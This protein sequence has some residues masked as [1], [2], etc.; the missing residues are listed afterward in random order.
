MNNWNKGWWK[1]RF[2]EKMELVNYIQECLYKDYSIPKIADELG[3]SSTTIHIII[4]KNN[5]VERRINLRSKDWLMQKYIE[6]K[7]SMNEIAKILGVTYQAV[8]FYIKKFNIQKRDISE[9]QKIASQRYRRNSNKH[10]PL[11]DLKSRGYSLWCDELWFS[12]AAEFLY[13]LI[14]RKNG[15]SFKFQKYIDGKRPDYIINNKMVIEIK[16]GRLGLDEMEYY[17]SYSKKLKEKYNYSYKIINVAENYKT[18]Y[19]KVLKKLRTLGAKRGIGLHV[20][21]DDFSGFV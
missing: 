13:Y 19:N 16:G 1:C 11:T 10:F 2:K 9:V 20:D 8:A 7:L 5:L 12:S 17:N 6:E 3:T 18:S 15:I 4:K 21:Y 14:L